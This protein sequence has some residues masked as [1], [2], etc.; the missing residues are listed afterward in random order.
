MKRILPALVLN[1]VFLAILLGSAGRINYW[2]AWIYFATSLLSSVLTRRVLKGNPELEQERAKPGS[3][4]KAWDKKLLG[5]GFLLTLAML[6]VAGLDA[7]RYHWIPILGWTWSLAGLVLILAGMGIFLW[8]LKVNRFFSSVVR[9]QT[10]RGHSV[11]TTGPYRVVRHPGN[12]GMI[13]GTLG[14][15]LLL[16]SAWSAIP[17]LVFIALIFVRTKLEDEAL[18]AELSGYKEYQCVTRYRLIPGIW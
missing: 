8:A 14:I 11:C 10:N 15:P 7:G 13:V 2:S 4:A 3:G 12:A 16:M 9:I 18:S 1:V 17:A 6:V 5:L